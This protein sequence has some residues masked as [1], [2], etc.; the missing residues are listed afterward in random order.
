MLSWTE[1][2]RFIVVAGA[3]LLA[4]LLAY[5]II[6]GPARQKTLEDREELGLIQQKIEGRIKAGQIQD[7]NNIKSVIREKERLEKQLAE[8]K[9]RMLFQ[10]NPRYEIDPADP[11]M[12]IKFSMLLQERKNL[13][14]KSAARQGIVI[15]GSFGFPTKNIAPSALPGYFGQLDIIDQVID[16]AITRGV[17]EILSVNQSKDT[18][19]F[20]SGMNLQNKFAQCQPVVIKLRSDFKTLSSFLYELL[21]MPRFLSLLRVSLTNNNPDGDTAME[22]VLA[23]GSLKALKTSATE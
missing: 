23:V 20:L 3:V 4:W 15:P 10:P 12:L 9:Q 6:I 14:S 16:L 22:L 11:E 1:N 2:K 7:D 5:L 18:R 13:L 17:T 21:V 19:A 8:L